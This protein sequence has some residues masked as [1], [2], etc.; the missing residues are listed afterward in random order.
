MEASNVKRYGPN[1]A[2]IPASALGSPV[3]W[4]GGLWLLF[5]GSY[6]LRA[7]LW[8]VLGVSPTLRQ[9]ELWVYRHGNEIGGAW[10]GVGMLVLLGLYILIR[11]KTTLYTLDENGLS[12]RLGYLNRHSPRGPFINYCDGIAFSHIVDV[13]PFQSPIQLL[14][15][16]RN[17][18]IV[19]MNGEVVTLRYVSNAQSLIQTIAAN[20]PLKRANIVGYMRMDQAPTPANQ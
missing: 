12:V 15:G 4:L 13:N 20:S 7:W 2:L 9:A 19:K 10:I 8:K 1:W 11:Y 14:F 5:F 6:G 17:I 16:T 3:F 18:E